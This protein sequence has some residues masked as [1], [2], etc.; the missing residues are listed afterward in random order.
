[1]EW[2]SRLLRIP[3]KEQN[4]EGDRISITSA[5]GVFVFHIRKN[6]LEASGAPTDR[7]SV[8]VV[9][10]LDVHDVWRHNLQEQQMA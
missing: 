7:D 5:C 2:A 4:E 3:I 8:Q 1:M 9:F 10:D 6:I